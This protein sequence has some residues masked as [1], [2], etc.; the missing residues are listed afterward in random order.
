MGHT[1]VPLVIFVK[2]KFQKVLGHMAQF[3]SMQ[4]LRDSA[5]RGFHL[6]V[7][8]IFKESPGGGKPKLQV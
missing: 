6:C 5:V 3:L 7:W 2:E 4:E 8:V 1:S